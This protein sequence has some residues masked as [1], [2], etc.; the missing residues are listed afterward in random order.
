MKRINF[1]FLRFKRGA[2]QAEGGDTELRAC[3]ERYPELAVELVDPPYSIRFSTVPQWHSWMGYSSDPHKLKGFGYDWERGIVTPC[4]RPADHLLSFVKTREHK[5]WTCDLQD[6]MGLSCSKG[7][8]EARTSMQEFVEKD[9][10]IGIREKSL[11]LLQEN[12]DHGEFRIRNQK[13]TSDHF[14]RCAWDHN[15]LFLLNAGGSHHTA[16]AQWLARE[17][18]QAVPLTGKLVEHEIDPGVV[19]A[20]IDEYDMFIVRSLYPKLDLSDPP[21]PHNKAAQ[22]MYDGLMSLKA[23]FLEHPLPRTYDKTLRIMFF[24]RDVEQSCQ[25]ATVLREAGFYD[26]GVHLER[27]LQNQL[28]PVPMTVPQNPMQ[29]VIPQDPVPVK[30][31]S[32]MRRPG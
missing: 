9:Y 27:L 12:L 10:R 7:P 20:L 31:R 19:R 4:E 22:S 32:A 29:T 5:E 1:N 23:T 30:A 15:R 28:D 24:P 18:Q 6:I 14:A 2:M 25:A 13:D 11:A 26:F 16:A 3:L 8:L 17:L 21:Y